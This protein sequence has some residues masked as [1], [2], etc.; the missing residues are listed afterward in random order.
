MPTYYINK[1]TGLVRKYENGKGYN[2]MPDFSWV[3]TGASEKLIQK[4]PYYKQREVE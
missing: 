2:L 3:Q 1:F 4:L